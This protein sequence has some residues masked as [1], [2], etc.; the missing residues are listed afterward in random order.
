[1]PPNRAQLFY[2]KIVELGPDAFCYLEE[3]ARKKSDTDEN[4]WRDFKGGGFIRVGGESD[5]KVKE[6]WGED[7]CAVQG[8]DSTP[9][10]GAFP[11][12]LTSA[13]DVERLRIKTDRTEKI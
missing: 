6:V 3:L 2:Q 13:T 11:V 1:M 4:E 9:Q 10:V 7:F 5:K 12:T 8:V